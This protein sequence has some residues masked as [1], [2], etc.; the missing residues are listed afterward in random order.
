M[1]DFD[2]LIKINPK[3]TKAY[4]NRGIIAMTMEA[5]QEAIKDF[6]KVIELEPNLADAHYNKAVALNH[7]GIY[8]E[9]I[10]Y[11]NKAIELNP[12]YSESYFNRG[13]SKS[14]TAYMKKDKMNEDEYKNMIKESED[15]FDKAY[16]LANEHIKN[17]ISDGLKKLAFLNMEAAENFCKKHDI[18]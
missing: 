4:L 3:Y 2:E 5:Y 6:D 18:K 13:I 15:D 11:Y 1:E 14:K 7:L 17:I 10:L 9:A 8:D 12:N 16:D